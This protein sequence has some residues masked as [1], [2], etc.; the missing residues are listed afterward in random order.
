MANGTA[1]D[2]TWEPRIDVTWLATSSRK[3][4]LLNGPGFAVTDISSYSD[5][6]SAKQY[7]RP[8]RLTLRRGRR[9][10]VGRRGRCRQLACPAYTA[11][12]IDRAN[13]IIADTSLDAASRRNAMTGSWRWSTAKIGAPGTGCL[14]LSLVDQLWLSGGAGARRPGLPRQRPS[15]SVGLRRAQRAALMARMG[16]DSER[17]AMIGS[18]RR[19]GDHE[20]DRHARP[21]RADEAR[22]RRRRVGRDPGSRWLMAR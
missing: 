16:H 9:S 21:L 7:S 20:R 18:G 19:P 22:R 13:R 11:K 5:P 14:P 1:T 6:S 17:A 3:F 12:A 2:A 10:L 4:L 15:A 8:S